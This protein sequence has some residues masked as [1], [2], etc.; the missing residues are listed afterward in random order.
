[1]NHGMVEKNVHA[2][3]G[4]NSRLDS[5]QAAMLSVK[6][7][8]IQSW[9]KKRIQHANLYSSLLRDVTSIKKPHVRE[10]VKHVFHLYVIRTDK[11]DALQKHLSTK[12]IQ[13][14]I[15]YP[16][17][18]P[19]LEPYQSGNH[20][21]E[22]FPIAYRDQQQILSLPLYPELTDGQIIFVC[23]SIKQFFQ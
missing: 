9:N 7:K 17:A 6:L 10:S 11:R 15:H 4:I 23:N 1:A 19:F 21:S 8:Y 12:G 2:M 14:S 3:E 20:K 5:L 18:L 22:E 13:T 16:L